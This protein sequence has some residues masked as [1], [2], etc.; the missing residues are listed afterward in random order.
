MCKLGLK[1]DTVTDPKTKPS[2]NERQSKMLILHTLAYRIETT[3][4]K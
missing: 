3:H 1:R 4:V 2:K